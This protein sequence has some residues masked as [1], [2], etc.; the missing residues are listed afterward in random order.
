ML[1]EGEEVKA[2]GG[3]RCGVQ[4][5]GGERSGM[6][7]VT[8]EITPYPAVFDDRLEVDPVFK[9]FQRD[10]LVRVQLPYGE[11]CWLATRYE[12]VRGVYGDRRFSRAAGFEHDVPR[13]WPGN[14]LIDPSMPLAMDPPRHT[15]LRRLTSGAFSPRRVREL[16]SWVQEEIDDLLD[17]MEQQGPPADFVAHFAW[18]LPIRVL[19]RI[20]GV[21]RDDSRRF[22]HWVETATGV[23]TPPVAREDASGQ[24]Q[25][26]RHRADCRPSGG[27]AERSAQRSRAR[28]R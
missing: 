10:G 2:P 1:L 12:H 8:D 25:R 17:H 15:R 24:A 21:P 4:I 22:R 18:D 19:A 23:L 20:M 5:N 16:R 7:S 26:V 3:R 9:D 14:A 28:H 11:S 6:A 27:A 13:V